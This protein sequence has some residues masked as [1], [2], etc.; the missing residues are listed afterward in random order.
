MQKVD[1]V[2][3]WVKYKSGD[4]QENP[5]I[6]DVYNT[7]LKMAKKRAHIDAILTATGASDI[8]TQDYEPNEEP[9]PPQ[10][11]TV[12]EAVQKLKSCWDLVDLGNLSNQY[13]TDWKN[14]ITGWTGD[15][16][17]GLVSVIKGQK[18]ALEEQFESSIEQEGQPEPQKEEPPT[19]AEGERVQIE[20]DWY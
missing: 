20:A 11:E 10:Y 6:A 4:K 19:S 5:D 3:R 14:G 2:W 17:N 8:F 13:K 9:P 16:W 7:V 1:G 18:K 12:A 15:Q